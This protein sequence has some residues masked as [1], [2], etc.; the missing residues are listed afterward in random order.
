MTSTWTSPH[1]LEKTAP[2]TTVVAPLAGTASGT[3]VAGVVATA[4][5]GA[6]EGLTVDVGVVVAGVLAVGVAAAGL[7]TMLAAATWLPPEA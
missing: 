1:L 4:A 3:V 6:S 7:V 5:D 2:S